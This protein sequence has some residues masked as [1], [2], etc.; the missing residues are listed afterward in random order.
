LSLE[1]LKLGGS[2]VTF[3][4]TPMA[5]NIKAIRRLAEEVSLAG[6]R[7]LVIIHGGGSYGHPLAKEHDIVSGYSSPRQLVGFSKTHQA[8]IN[9]NSIIIEAFL[10]S[11]VPVVSIAPSSFIV[12]DDRRIV[13]IDFNLI[14]RFIESDFIPVLYGDA[15][16]DISRRFTILSGDQLSVRLAIELKVERL[17]FGVDVDGVYTANPNLAPDAKLI[18]DLSLSQIKGMTQ[19]GEALSTDV[20]GGMI[21]KINEARDAVEADIKVQ[22]INALK[23]GIIQSALKWN[24]VPGTWLRR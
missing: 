10:D 20:T 9:L 4:K 22:L 17:L 18:E 6:S 3:K 15:V 16:L 24:P 2:V 23:P 5:P 7:K 12:T 21:G 8:M 11:G 19:I 14:K 13:N 1:I